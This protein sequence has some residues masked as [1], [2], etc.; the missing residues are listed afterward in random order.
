MLTGPRASKACSRSARPSCANP[1]ENQ[2]VS[3]AS[4][5]SRS[6]AASVRSGVAP[7]ATARALTGVHA[8]LPQ[9]GKAALSGSLSR[10][11]ATGR[12]C[13][14]LRRACHRA[15]PSWRANR[16]RWPSWRRAQSAAGRYPVPPGGV[17]GVEDR[18]GQPDDN[19]GNRQHPQEQQPPRACDRSRCRRRADQAAAQHPETTAAPARAA[20]PAGSATGSAGPRARP[21]SQGA[22]KPMGP[23]I[24]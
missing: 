5:P 16:G 10:R 19:R 23:S 21:A 15:T 8:T 12:D 24:I 20:P 22:V 14:P 18:T 9:P 3:N 11:I 17:V 1:S 7:R 6:I 13:R 2:R 4:S